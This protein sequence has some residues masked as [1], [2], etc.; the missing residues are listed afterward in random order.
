MLN[1][2]QLLPGKPTAA[3]SPTCFASVCAQTGPN[4]A[5]QRPQQGK[6]SRLITNVLTAAV[7]TIRGMKQCGRD[8]SAG[9]SWGA[10]VGVGGTSAGLRHHRGRT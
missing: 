9:G 2:L 3:R 6:P 5:W 1:K 10:S 4:H 8:G 7:G